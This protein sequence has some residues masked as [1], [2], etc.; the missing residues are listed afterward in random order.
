MYFYLGDISRQQG[1][2]PKAISMLERAVAEQ[3]SHERARSMLGPLGASRTVSSCSA[4]M[5]PEQ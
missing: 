3:T 5:M 1:D 2:V 4:V